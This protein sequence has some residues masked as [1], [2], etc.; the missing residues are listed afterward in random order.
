M[1]YFFVPG[2][3]WK[4]SLA[5]LR[6]VLL[7]Q[8]VT[9]ELTHTDE[10]LFTIETKAG[11]D[12]LDQVFNSLGGFIKYGEVVDE[13]FEYLEKFID[14]LPTE[15]QKIR[16]SL[17]FYADSS[18]KRT[19][20][21]LAQ[22]KNRLGMKMKQW[23]KDSG[24][25]SRF[26]SSRRDLD[27]S[28][29]LLHKN[30]VLQEGFELNF[31]DFEATKKP[32]WGVTHGFQDFEGFSKR[33]YGRPRANRPKGMLPPKLARMMLNLTGM[34]EARIWDPFC[35]SGTILMEGF[36]LGHIMMGSD[37]DRVAIEESRENLEWLAGESGGGEAIGETEN[38]PKYRVFRHDIK[39]GIPEKLEFDAIVSEPYLG[40]VQKREMTPQAIES[41]THKI[42]PVYDAL[43]RCAEQ[44]KTPEKLKKL[45]LVVPAFKSRDGWVEMSFPSHSDT[46]E[47]TTHE[48][49]DTPLHW[50]RPNSIIR[51]NIKIFRF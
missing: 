19:A 47:D 39:N 16:F 26:V 31:F 37:V 6:A 24:I 3:K 20:S 45:V 50:D 7:C 14:K 48:L 21:K 36:L 35:G 42:R 12:I 10:N 44:A 51:R 28:L 15:T 33:D 49:S 23:L 32:I 1:K 22:E 9:F 25:K 41:A 8:E 13:P 18:S 2:R 17:S 34:Q 40:P 27:T 43:E 38:T 5:E 29:V 30:Q 46:L 4:L 11:R